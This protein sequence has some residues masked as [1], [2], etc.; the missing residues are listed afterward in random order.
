MKPAGALVLFLLLTACGGV[1]PTPPA[2]AASPAGTVRLYTSVVQQ[3]VD[4]VVKPY[5]AAHPGVAVETFRAPTGQLDAR[6]AAEQRL[7]GV[8][9]DV[10]WETDPLSMQQFAGQHLL[11]QWTPSEQ[12][13]VPAGYRGNGYWGTRILNLVIVHRADL[14]T[15][16]IDWNDLLSPAFRDAVAI[17]DP[18]FAGSAYGAL[19]YFGMAPGY[20]I[21]FYRKLKG[22]GAVQVSAIGDVITGVAE[23][24]FKAGLALDVTAQQA[25]TK[26]SPIRIAWP[27]SGAI[28]IYSPIAEIAS[29]PNRPAAEAFIDFV[30]S[31]PGQ[32]AIAATGWQPIRAGV[33]GGPV[34]GGKQVEPDWPAAF[35]RQAD[36][37]REYRSIFGA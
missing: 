31:E 33:T 36:L 19:A 12:H 2:A 34:P 17:P 37:L 9:A 8:Q 18:G 6:I 26:G 1:S 27:K 25:I 22:N 4:A 13:A 24:R 32:K 35:K 3:T 15:A 28:A 29:T 5:Q 23:G 14:A 7:G 20:G 10:L 16:P 11:M 21:D 30:L